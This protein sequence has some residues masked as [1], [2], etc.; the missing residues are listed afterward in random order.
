[1]REREQVKEGKREEEEEEEEEEE[2]RQDDV[3]VNTQ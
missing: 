1:M 3:K 2:G